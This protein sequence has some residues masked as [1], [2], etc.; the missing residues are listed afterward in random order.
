[1]A[2][3]NPK[4]MKAVAAAIKKDP[5]VTNG[6]LF[7]QAKSMDPEIG[8]LSR[9][10]FNARYT[11]QVKRK[12]P[13][14]GKKSRAARKRA[15]T[16]AGLRRGFGK[17]AGA[18]PDRDAIR[19]ALLAFASD[20]TAADERKDLVKVLANIDRYVDRIAKVSR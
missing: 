16:A 13:G 19:A 2:E 9:R 1:M 7:E 12:L 3:T 10:Q 15:P 14:A 8:S 20:L 6:D 11:L 17:R 5:E 18:G 4:V